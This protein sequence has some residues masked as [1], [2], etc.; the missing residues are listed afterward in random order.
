MCPLIIFLY[1]KTFPLSGHFVS[2]TFQTLLQDMLTLFRGVNTLFS[3]APN[4]F[5][6]LSFQNQPEVCTAVFDRTPWAPLAVDAELPPGGGSSPSC[7]TRE[8]RG[9]APEERRDAEKN[10]PND[11]MCHHF[12]II[13]L[14][15]LS[16]DK[17]TTVWQ[18]LLI[19]F[20]PFVGG[21]N[22][23]SPW[24]QCCLVIRLNDKGEK[25]FNQSQALYLLKFSLTRFSFMYCSS[26]SRYRIKGAA[27]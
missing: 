25:Q 5:L 18:N 12:Y 1:T 9:W 16:Y 8:S 26:C 13:H 6:V 17:V 15:S 10:R 22:Q 7:S 21:T 19:A 20:N 4:S 23:T 24:P 3:V 2:V 27:A 11:N 14:T